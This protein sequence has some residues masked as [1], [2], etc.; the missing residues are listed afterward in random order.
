ML[1]SG[2]FGEGV[3]AGACVHD[4]QCMHGNG[5][6]ATLLVVCGANGLHSTSKRDC[7]AHHCTPART[8]SKRVC[9]HRIKAR[10]HS[11]SN[12]HAHACT[13]TLREREK[14]RERD[15]HSHSHTQ[16][17]TQ[18]HTHTHIHTHTRTHT[19]AH[20]H[21]RTHVHAHTQVKDSWRERRMHSDST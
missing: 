15:S 10:L 6:K 17:E 7:T 5:R 2:T 20:A 11:T 16:R 4:I 9:T 1:T 18:K 8:T 19:H 12:T 21:T 14:E 3:G 13:H